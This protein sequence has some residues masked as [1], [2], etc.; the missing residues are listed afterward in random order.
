[1]NTNYFISKC[2]SRKTLAAIAVSSALLFSA[3]AA[4]AVDGSGIVKGHIENVSGQSIANATITLKHKTKGL[5]YSISTNDNGEYIL[6]NVPVGDYDITISKNGFSQASENNVEVTIGQALILDSQLQSA[7][8]ENIERIE[9]TGSSIRRVDL[10]NSTSGVTLTQAE[11]N[12]LPVSTGFESIAL[13]A[14]G[15]AAPGGSNFKGASSFGGASSAENGYY[16]NGLN[17]TNIRTGLGSIA[18]PWEAISQTQV[19]TGGVTPEFGGAMG[20]IVNAVSKSGNNDF[21]FGVEARWDPSSLRSE[22]QSIYDSEGVIQTNTQRDSTDFKYVRLWASGSIIEDKLFYYGLYAPRRTE[23]E[24]AGQTTATDRV[25]ESDRYFAKVDWFI[26]PEHSI[27]LTAMNNKETYETSVFG[28]DADTNVVSAQIGLTSPGREGGQVYG[29]SYNGYFGDNFSVSAVAGRTSENIDNVAISADPGV[30]DR[31]FG[32]TLSQH[33]QSSISEEE[34]IRDQARIDFNWDLESHSI[35]FGVD[36]TNVSVDFT[37]G[38]N[39]IGDAE[40][41]WNVRTSNGDDLSGL[42]AGEHYIERRVRTRFTDSEV[43][44]LAFYASDTWQVT[45]ELVLKFGARYSGFENTVSDGRAY[46]D[47]D[48]QFAPRLQAIYDVFGDGTSKA[49][50]TFGRYF[51]PVSANMNITQGSSSIE[52][53]E[54]FSLAELDGDGSPTLSADGSPNRG[55]MVRD[56]FYRQRGIT[57]PGLISSASIKPMYSDEFTLGYE[58]EV[59]GD[60]TAG[61]RFVYRELGR[62]VEDTD[63]GPV[64]AKKLAELGIE[65]NVGQGS[66]YVL[67]NPGE[68]IQM[69][70]DFDGD[71]TIDNVNLS[72]D[73]LQLQQPERKY[74]AWE[75]TLDG[76]V[77]DDLKIDA[78]YT[79]SHSYGNTEGLVKT[80]NN[81]ADPGWTTSYD[82]ADL[83][84]HAYGDLPNDHRHSFKFNGT[85][86]IT[87]ELTL[88]LVSRMTSGRPTNYFSVH[89]VDVDSC[90]TGSPWDACIS[91]YYGNASHYD[92]NGRPAPRGSVGN[93]PW[94]INVDMSLTYQTEIFGHDFS[95]KGTVYNLFNDDAALNINESRQK[96]VTVGDESVAVVDPEYGRVTSRQGA[97]YFSIVARYEF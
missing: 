88:G 82:Y 65:D 40:G 77:N 16:L 95:V 22:H 56:R 80:D 6:R 34:Y 41:W 91:K 19:Q 86:A 67:N 48:N 96:F 59:F 7:S 78:S 90:Q 46:V 25:Y 1:M 18:L 64:L 49:Y 33:T 62:S 84:D 71:G 13:L 26:S 32:T 10:E 28:Y 66:Y 74:L 37:S 73:E 51:Q 20:G 54:H 17:V 76:K 57:E 29:I 83:M 4:L 92:Y 87:E 27:G 12:V 24:W 61:V 15:T 21:S 14:P 43:N 44:S 35:Q 31:R 60:M 93:L 52:W 53:F 89:P 69:S 63:V 8:S 36:Y 47:I 81:Q 42:D 68:A 9:V 70:Y 97:R 5:V 23:S 79:W 72:Q 30:W 85:Y 45:D 55:A 75:F 39:G 58:Q 38:Q 2:P 3:P 94:V 11:L 50:A